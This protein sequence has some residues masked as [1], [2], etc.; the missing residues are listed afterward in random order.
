M[1]ARAV[2]MD[3]V[4]RGDH[5]GVV[6]ERDP[7]PVRRPARPPSR[8]DLHR[9][10][11]IVEGREELPTGAWIRQG[12]C[13]HELRTGGRPHRRLLPAPV[14]G[15][16]LDI[17]AGHARR[18]DVACRIGR[19]RPPGDSAAVRG[20]WLVAQPD[21]LRRVGGRDDML[22]RAIGVHH[23]KLVM[24]AED[25]DE[26]E[27]RTIERPAR[28]KSVVRLQRDWVAAVRGHGVDAGAVRRVGNPAAAD[29]GRRRHGRH[30]C[31]KRDQRRNQTQQS[32]FSA[33]SS[34]SESPYGP[35]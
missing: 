33:S 23:L 5:A 8:R 14:R 7:R 19:S 12:G 20:P 25:L 32:H 1:D 4:D 26:R 17:A 6:D 30:Q 21:A 29:L 15:D 24:A 2:R 34:M 35:L 28:Q 13:V 16:P 10:R 9:R 22:V 3:G 18:V 27:F 31:D 11:A